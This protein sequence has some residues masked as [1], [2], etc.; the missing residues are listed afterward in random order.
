MIFQ[1]Y[2]K[3]S[4]EKELGWAKSGVPAHYSLGLELSE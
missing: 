1:N 2:N 4:W 3:R